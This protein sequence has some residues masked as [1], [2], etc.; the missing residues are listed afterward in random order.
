MCGLGLRLGL[1]GLSIGL[2]RFRA[3]GAGPLVLLDLGFHIRQP[4]DQ[5][6]VGIEV[7]HREQAEAADTC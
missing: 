4:G 2:N 3:P 5:S 1:T 6:A 7:E